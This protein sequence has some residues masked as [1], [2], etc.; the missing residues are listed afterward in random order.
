[1]VGLINRIFTFNENKAAKSSFVSIDKLDRKIQKSPK[2][3]FD[4]FDIIYASIE[5]QM[6]ILNL[7]FS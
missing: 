5:K 3:R 1:M 6:Q 7:F 4:M 2:N